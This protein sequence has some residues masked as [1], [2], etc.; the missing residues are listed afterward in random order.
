M[1]SCNVRLINMSDQTALESCARRRSPARLPNDP[2]PR[3]PP[4]LLMPLAI[5]AIIPRPPPDDMSGGMRRVV[6]SYC[7][8][9]INAIIIARMMPQNV[10]RASLRRLRHNSHA[11]SK[12]PCWDA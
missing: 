3:P 5:A 1:R 9:I 11:H 2:P 12:P 4:E 6:D 10:H 8:G 7:F